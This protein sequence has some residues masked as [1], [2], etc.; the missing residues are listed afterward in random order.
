MTTY[1]AGNSKTISSNILS[2]KDYALVKKVFRCVAAIPPIFAAFFI[3][4]LGKITNFTGVTG[5]ALAFI[6][7]AL[8]S[9][10]SEKL[11]HFYG[12]RSNTIYSHK[13]W[14]SKI[15]QLLV[16][17]LGSFMTV[18]VIFCNIYFGTMHE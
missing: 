9:Y 2:N 1:Y 12:L 5:F 14:T 8:L 10:Y 13:I 18:Y 15:F 3:N 4:D 17:F 11:L 7:P 6:F 16:F